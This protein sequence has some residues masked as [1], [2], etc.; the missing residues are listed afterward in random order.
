MTGDIDIRIALPESALVV[1][2]GAS[3]SGKS[4]FARAHFRPTEVLSSDFFRSL[5]A[6]DENDL[7]ATDDAFEALHYIAA[8]R[9]A[10]LRLTVV[11]A[12]NVQ[13]FARQ[14]LLD[15]A[16][17]YHV[18]PVAIVLDLPE[19]VCRDRNQSRPERDLGEHVVGQQCRQLR[20]SLKKLKREGFR[21]VYVLRSED[22]V[23]RVRVEREKVWPDRRDEG[24]PFDIIGDVHGC[25]DELEALLEKLGYATGEGRAMSGDGRKAIFLG[26][27]VDRGPQIPQV[28]DLVLGMVEAETA[29]WVP[30]NHDIRL[31]RA[32]QGRKVQRT[33]GL[34][35]SLEQ[36][37]SRPPAFR[38]K[39]ADFIDSLIS[40]YVLDQGRLVV[41]HAGMKEDLAGRT[42]AMVREFAMYGE[43]TGEID[44]FG[45]PVRLDWA[46]EYR[47]EA[48][49]AYGHTPVPQAEWLNNTINLDTGCVFGGVLSA[50]RYPEKELVS[51]PAARVYAEPVRPLAIQGDPSPALSAQQAH[52]DL[53]DIGDV[54]GKRLVDTRLLSRITIREEHTIPALEV[55][56]RFSVDPRW[57]I[58]LPPTMAPSR[59]SSRPEVL[60]HPD[61]A[62]AY[63]RD[64]GV[65]QSLCEEKHM[66]SRA[67]VVICKDEE[68]AGQRFGLS[69][70]GPGACY[71]RT[72]RRFFDDDALEAEFLHRVGSAIAQAGL[73]DELDTGWMLLDCELMP[74]SARAQ[75]LLQEQYAAV[76]AAARV[77]LDAVVAALERASANQVDVGSWLETYQ[78]RAQRVARYIDAYRAY[79]WPVASLDGLKLAP[80]HLLATEGVVHHGQTHLW[81]LEMLARLNEADPD[82]LHPTAHQLV[83]LNDER[84]L[85]EATSWW[86]EKTG[87]GGEGMVVKPLDFVAQGPRGL[88]QPALKCRGREYLRII[89]GPEYTTP[90]H[91][92]QLRQRHLKPKQS[93]ARR[94][95][96]LG[97][98]ALERFVQGEPLRRVHECVFG[99]LALESER[100]D[101][102]L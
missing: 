97:L 62:F 10:N 70:A 35:E 68:V 89:Y 27:L 25:F 15:L 28:L 86:E 30:G 26:D 45:L 9:L 2:V 41:A 91:L 93:L 50:L 101:P 12:T 54:L 31:M 40:H 72:G 18:L 96:S 60:E 42:S 77:S 3:G 23:D 90:D 32:L 83:D 29:L 59:T 11:D 73:W 99:V 44:E 37:E 19:R 58:Y 102:R 14:P 84:S 76:G 78:A 4:A 53:L 6:D 46:A 1:L 16:R 98:E 57:L 56:S 64:H 39:V 43:A 49:V 87:A 52:D 22:E 48:M 47:G 80:F 7:K 51:V 5:V 79:C 94:E 95:F 61:E 17:Q 92:A 67:I 24:G 21:R 20:Q 63:Y 8:K 66:G 74:W 71:T 34:S 69:G 38:K 55:M 13:A 88:L 82:L 100:V 65:Q 36:L 33:H 75:Q 85:R 81:H